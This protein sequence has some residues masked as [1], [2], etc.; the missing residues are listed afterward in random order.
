MV[1]KI[2]K[3]NRYYRSALKKFLILSTILA[4]YF[5]YLNLKFTLASSV[6]IT[7]LT[8]SF[9]VL[10]TPFIDS[11]SMLNFPLRFF[12][13]IRMFLSEVIVWLVAVSGN[14]V[15]FKFYKHQYHKTIPT[16]IFYKILTNP[17]PYWSIILLSAAGAFLSIKF[18]DNTYDPSPDQK[19]KSNRKGLGLKTVIVILIFIAVALIYYHLLKTMGIKLPINL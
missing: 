3:N 1:L 7:F 14:I 13:G 9:F 5:V 4:V 6:I 2:K 11:G 17:Y 8:W 10:C 15:I 19:G 18:C 12:I 16:K